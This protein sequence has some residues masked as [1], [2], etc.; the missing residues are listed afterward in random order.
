MIAEAPTFGHKRAAMI[1][2]CASGL[3]VLFVAQVLV[4]LFLELRYTPSPQ[5]AYS[6]VHS[7][8]AGGL[9][10]LRAFHYWSSFL[11]IAG[12]FGVILWMFAARWFNC[13]HNRMWIAIWLLFLVSLISQIT[14]NLLPFDRH[15][16]QTAVIEAGVAR[17]MPL[18]GPT[19]ASLVLG[20]DQFG[21]STL[22]R[23]HVAH[24][25]LPLFGLFAVWLFWSG[26]RHENKNAFLRWAPLGLACLAMLMA[27]APLGSAAS[28]DDYG[29]YGAQVSW[30]TWPLHGALNLFSELSPSLGWIGSGLLPMLFAAFVF[31]APWVAQK[32]PPKAIQATFLGFCLFFF[33]A[34]VF[35]GGKPAPLVG[36][37][38]PQQV[39][40]TGKTATPVDHSL[41][42]RG[43][44]LFNS[45]GCAGCHGHNGRTPTAGP[46]LYGVASKRGSD[47]QWYMKFIQDPK[48]VKP[49]SMM[50]PFAQLTAD[51]TRAIAEF[52]IHQK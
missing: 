12:S 44:D 15:G 49:T 47:P 6:D 50:P 33:V 1:P 11:L 27:P 32:V 26:S 45:K 31:A 16:V 25:V 24:V 42:A 9:A 13:G 35:F 2:G 37:R 28:Q 48:S 30:Y 3:F 23:W 36:S 41:Y 21:E 40:P 34:A 29:S 52:L 8:Q 43:R 46:N 17:Q 38:D 39:R 19:A 7:M 22:E 5:S 4:S 51:E 18:V 20:G 10:I 14:G